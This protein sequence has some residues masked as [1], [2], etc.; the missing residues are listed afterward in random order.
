MLKKHRLCPEERKTER[1]KETTVISEKETKI[2]IKSEIVGTSSKSFKDRPMEKVEE[3][4]KRKYKVMGTD[5]EP[6]YD[7][8]DT[9]EEKVQV[10]MLTKNE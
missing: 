6:E 9:E 4:S 8:L 5:I 2:V 7:E 10:E 3:A 1:Q